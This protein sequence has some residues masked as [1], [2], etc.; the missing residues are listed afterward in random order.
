MKYAIWFFLM[1]VCPYLC[2]SQSKDDRYFLDISKSLGYA[3]GIKLSNDIIIEKYPDLSKKAL[4]AHHDFNS[5]HKKAIENMEKE[6]FKKVKINREEYID[7]FIDQIA[8]QYNVNNIS[9]FDANEYL[10]NFKEEKILG[11]HELYAEFVSILLR[12]NPVYTSFPTKEFT[13]GFRTRFDS[14][15]HSKSKGLN[16]S[17]EYPKSWISQE[18]K[19]PNV[20]TLVKSYDGLCVVS[21]VIK[22][23]LSEMGTDINDLSKEDLKYIRSGEFEMEIYNEILDDKYGRELIK[24]VGLEKVA[25]YS[26]ERTKIDGQP[27]IV[28]AASGNLKRALGEANVYTINHLVIYRNY[29]I[30]INSIISSFG[31]DLY[32]EKKKYEMLC[33][34]IANSLVIKSKW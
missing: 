24:E 1:F 27:T 3:Y 6:F 16:L 9:H 4:L 33:K 15:K 23:I 25:D 21:L 29:V 7:R 19:R 26:F 2:N 17:I 30:S 11:N 10:K 5:F 8:D 18:G 22:D 13:D 20:L 34:L 12:H 31:S 28:I 32:S 14:D